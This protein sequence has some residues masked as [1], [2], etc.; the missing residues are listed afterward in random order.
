[1]N[2][3]MNSSLKRKYGSYVSSRTWWKQFIEITVK[4][5]VQNVEKTI[6]YLTTLTFIIP[7]QLKRVAT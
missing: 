1:M 2:E 7:G 3:S 6:N 4:C 5:L